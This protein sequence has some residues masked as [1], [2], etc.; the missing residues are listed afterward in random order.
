M[1][2]ETEGAGFRLFAESLMRFW[3]LVFQLPRKSCIRR[4][5]EYVENFVANH[6]LSPSR[7]VCCAR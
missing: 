4:E 5:R 3:R 1:R 7:I 6:K 2:Q